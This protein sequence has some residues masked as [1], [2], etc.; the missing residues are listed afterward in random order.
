MLS[1]T[2]TKEILGKNRFY[3]FY[4]K[5]F[6]FIFLNYSKEK[7]FSFFMNFSESLRQELLIRKNRKTK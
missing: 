4:Q 1:K 3:H 5:I 2:Q 6:F 7:L